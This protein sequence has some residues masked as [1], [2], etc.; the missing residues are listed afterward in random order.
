M[1]F[2][3][4]TNFYILECH[5][6]WD[7]EIGRATTASTYMSP[8]YMRGTDLSVLHIT[9]FISTTARWGRCYWDLIYKWG[10]RCT[11]K[12]TD[13]LKEQSHQ[14]QSQ[15]LNLGRL[16]PIHNFH[17]THQDHHQPWS[18]SQNLSIKTNFIPSFFYFFAQSWC[19]LD[20]L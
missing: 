13:L 9:P 16:P 19:R 7:C 18:Q 5:Y 3:A 10:S 15:N 17:A 1:N 12:L 8:Q 4:P 20:H 2:E 14:Q 11:E 6:F